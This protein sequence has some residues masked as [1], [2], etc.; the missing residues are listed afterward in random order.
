MLRAPGSFTPRAAPLAPTTSKSD[1]TSVAPLTS[2]TN[3]NVTKVPVP[4]GN[5]KPP[6]ENATIFWVAS[7]KLTSST[8]S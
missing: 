6:I 1:N 5:D 8:P 7:L 4:A 3:S 2:G